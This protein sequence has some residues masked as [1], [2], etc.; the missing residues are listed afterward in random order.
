PILLLLLG[1]EALRRSSPRRAAV[2]VALAVSAKLSM[3]L[4]IPFL[5]VY[6]FH[7]KRLR[8]YFIPF[9]AALVGALL[10]LQAPYFLSPGARDMLFGNPELAKVYDAAFTLG[11]GLQVYL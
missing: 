8:V 11:N 7:N 3:V 1:L 4:A 9:S 10:L 2:W 6:L 5:L